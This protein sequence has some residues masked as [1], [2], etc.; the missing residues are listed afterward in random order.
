MIKLHPL[1]KWEKQVQERI[2]QECIFTCLLKKLTEFFTN[3]QLIF[4][5][6]WSHSGS[7][8]IMK[9]QWIPMVRNLG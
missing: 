3:S 4:F 7:L 8:Q 9:R 6:D 2:S 1:L 5:L